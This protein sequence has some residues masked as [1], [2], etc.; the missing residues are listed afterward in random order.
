MGF[1]KIEKEERILKESFS[2]VQK[3]MVCD[4]FAD[5]LEYVAIKGLMSVECT[6]AFQ[7]LIKPA[8]AKMRKIETQIHV[9]F[10]GTKPPKT[11]IALLSTVG[12]LFSDCDSESLSHLVEKILKK[13]TTKGT[14]AEYQRCLAADK[15]PIEIGEE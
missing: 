10:A 15:E 13:G 4:L 5:G 1:I 11:K 3:N 12:G 14:F 7:H 6:G 8:I 2:I 9:L